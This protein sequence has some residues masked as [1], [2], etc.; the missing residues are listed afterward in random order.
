MTSDCGTGE[1]FCTWA[2]PTLAQFGAP[3]PGGGTGLALTLTQEPCAHQGCCQNGVC[4]NWAGAHLASAACFLYGTVEFEASISGLPAATNGVFYVG[5]RVTAPNQNLQDAQNE[6]DIGLAPNTLQPLPSPSGETHTHD[7]AS[8][9]GSGPELVLA[10][11][12]PTLSAETYD[13][14]TTPQFTQAESN[15]FTSYKFVWGPGSLDYYVNGQLFRSV[16]TQAGAPAALRD[17]NVPWRPQDL[18]LIVRTNVGTSQPAP[19]GTV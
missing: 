11:F 13:Q 6:I 7:V 3:L 4:A 18:R 17:A 12:G 2:D 9:P 15:A 10:Y 14:S 19:A 5:T 8:V 16:R 1:S